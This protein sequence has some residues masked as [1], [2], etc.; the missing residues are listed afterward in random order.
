MEVIDSHA[1]VHDAQ[2]DADRADVIVRARAAGVAAMVTVGTNRA[3]SAQAVAL[4]HRYDTVWA[5]VGLHPLYVV[6]VAAAAP[7][8]HVA[9]EFDA[10]FYA[11]L[12][13][14]PKVVAIGEVGLDYH[15]FGPGDDEGA[16]KNK[17]KEVLRAFVEVCNAVDKPMVIHCWDAYDDMCALLTRTPVARAGIIHSFVGSW[18]TAQQFVDMG[19]SIG[20]NGIATYGTSYDKLLRTVP[21]E[22][23]VIE[24]DC[25]YL[26]PRPLARELRCEPKDVVLVAEKIAAVRG[27]AAEEVARVTTENARRVFGIA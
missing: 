3:T 18:K 19:Y 11:R 16:I 9:E 26:P 21:L 23:L 4:A 5:T 14:D 6:T 10:D 12:A 22:R 20:V 24:T 2:F 8:E 1:H 27:I 13:R 15:H 7:D 25:P 17:Q